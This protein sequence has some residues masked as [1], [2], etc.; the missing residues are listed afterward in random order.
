MELKKITAIVRTSTLSE[1]EHRLRDVG[2]KGL[3]VT[4]VLGFGEYANFFRDDWHVGHARVEIFADLS[5]VDR[6]VSSIMDA[7]HTGHPGDGIIAV[8]TV[9][10]VFRIRE[11]AEAPATAL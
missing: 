2:V 5:T 7:A 6:I 8:T 1:V 3:T 9:E 10:Q 11:R 4:Q